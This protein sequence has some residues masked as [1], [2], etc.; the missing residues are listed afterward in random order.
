MHLTFSY[1]YYVTLHNETAPVPQIK[2]NVQLLSFQKGVGRF[3]ALV[4]GYANSPA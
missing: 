3:N 1:F 2:N 4:L